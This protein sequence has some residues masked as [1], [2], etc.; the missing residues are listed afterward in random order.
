MRKDLV[1]GLHLNIMARMWN[2]RDSGE[3]TRPARKT[4]IA[5]SLEMNLQKFFSDN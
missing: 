4:I 3:F 5:G 2:C 1:Q